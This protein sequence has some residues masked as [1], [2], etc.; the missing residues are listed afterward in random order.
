MESVILYGKLEEYEEVLRILVY[1]LR[2]FSAVEDYCLWRFEGRVLFYRQRFFY[3]LLVI[4]FG[5]GFFVF[6]LIVVVVD[7][8]NY[9]VTEFDAVQ[10]LQLLSGIWLV[11]FFCSFLTGVM[12]DSVYIRRIVQV[13]VG[14]VKFEN[15]IYK[16]D[17]VRVWF[18]Q[19]SQ[20]FD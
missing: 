7:F 4:Y 1:E 19:A 20:F 15:L 14:L 10:V 6:E 16:Y 18:F 13:V 3:T 9:Y 8:L 2:D 17:K 5:F 12:R 11:Q